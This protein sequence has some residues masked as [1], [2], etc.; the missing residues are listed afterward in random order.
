MLIS[1]DESGYAVGDPLSPRRLLLVGTDAGTLEL[2]Q[3]ED[4]QIRCV[5]ESSQALAYVREA[6]CDLVVAS[7]GSDPSAGL[8]LVRRLRAIRP[9]T[10]VILTGD[11]GSAMIVAA[12]R[13]RVYGYFHE[14]VTQSALADMAHLALASTSWRDDIRV[15]SADLSW[16]EF[17]VRCKMEAAER[18]TQFA[19][20]ILSCLPAKACEDASAAF[21]ELLFNAVEH[22][23]HLD[24]RKRARVSLVHGRHALVGQIQD[25]GKGFSL[26][27]LPHAAISNPDDSP[28]RHVEIREQVG[29]RPGGFGILIS[30]SLVDELAYNERGNAAM[31]VKYL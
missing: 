23:G 10:R 14:P 21:R 2:L 25:P 18:A 27:R 13:Q 4:R 11:A 30:R 12:M 3:R 15:T 26:G 19:R 29:Q 5:Q 1:A 7:H 17:D 8:R 20:E 6:P 22:G 31:F 24:P 9:E 28:T 16:V